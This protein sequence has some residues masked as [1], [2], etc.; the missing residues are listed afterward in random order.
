V[1]LF[2]RLVCGGLH[3]LNKNDPISNRGRAHT[4]KQAGGPRASRRSL[5]VAILKGSGVI[6]KAFLGAFCCTDPKE[7]S[8]GPW[9]VRRLNPIG[10]GGAGEPAFIGAG[11]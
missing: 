11:G 2:P 1:G 9:G 4:P 5:P 10:G 6:P 7:G 8:Q 3:G